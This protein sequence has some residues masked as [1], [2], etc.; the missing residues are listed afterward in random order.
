MRMCVQT[1]CNV[2]VIMCPS[3]LMSYDVFGLIYVNDMF[4]VFHICVS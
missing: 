3:S 4:V 2:A 1:L